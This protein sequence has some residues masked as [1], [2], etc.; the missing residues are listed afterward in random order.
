MLYRFAL[1]LARRAGYPAP[2]QCYPPSPTK[3]SILSA[4][5][6]GM[7]SISAKEAIMAMRRI[8]SRAAE[9]T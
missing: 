7:L 4:Y 6:I 1:L 5:R 2:Q 3:P 9:F 8:K